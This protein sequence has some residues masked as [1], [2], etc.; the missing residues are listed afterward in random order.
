MPP[1]PFPMPATPDAPLL[2]IEDL[3]VRYD[4]P[5]GVVHAVDGVSLTVRRGET[6]SLV[7]ESGCGKSTLGRAILRLIEPAGGR[8]R[9]EGEELTGLSRRALCPKRRAVQMVFQDPFGSLDPRWTVGQLLAEPL[10][11]HGIGPR[12]ERRDRV[13]GLLERVGLPADAAQRHPHEFSGG[14]RQRIGIARALALEPKLVVCDEPV[15]ALDVSVQ[16]QILNL[17]VDL[18]R[19]L[20]VAFLFI[21]HDLSVVEYI[22]DRVGVMYLGRI[23]ETAPREALWRAPLHPYTRAL[24][25]AVPDIERPGR[26]RAPLSGDV[27]S[28][29]APPSGCRFH[30]RCPLAVDRCRRDAPALRPAGDPDHHVACHLAPGGAP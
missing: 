17:L 14:Q 1:L 26:A 15:S 12:A 23:V 30:T 28:A 22:A 7:G 20:G 24:F 9:L 18:Q 10:H 25:D 2:A 6:L 3:V 13:L 4:T 29:Y 8:I 16:A 27:P 11:V 19:D 5:H 21:S